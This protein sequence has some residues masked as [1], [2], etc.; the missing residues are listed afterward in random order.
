[1]T[2]DLFFNFLTHQKGENQFGPLQIV[3]FHQPY[4]S[5]QRV[6]FRTKTTT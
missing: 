1:M 4:Y 6:L 2:F 3:T 5:W